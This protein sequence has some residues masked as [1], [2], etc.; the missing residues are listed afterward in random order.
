MTAKIFDINQGIVIA[1]NL[2]KNAEK[3]ILVG[4]CF[5]ILHIG[6]LKF[7][8]NA[9]KLG[10]K[11]FI[12]LESDEKV[13]KLK[14]KG[15]PV[16]QQNDRAEALSLIKDVDVI[17]KLPVFSK[18]ED[19]RKLVLGLKPNIIAVTENDPNIGKKKTQVK[20]LGGEL[21]IIEF[22]KSLSSS[23]LAQILK[24]EKNY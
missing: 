4:G 5:D 3:I 13:R 23:R 20:V 2:K 9:K 8:E 16:F 18:D 15:R 14:G 6:H 1:R 17:I 11:L 21:K 12:L 10:G 24:K 7:L 19:Y 22:F